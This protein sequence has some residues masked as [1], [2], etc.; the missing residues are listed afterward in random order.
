MAKLK[1]PTYDWEFKN[2]LDSILSGST[3]LAKNTTEKWTMFRDI[4]TKIAKT[5]LGPKEW[6]YQ[7][8]FDEN[9]DNIA[10][11]FRTKNKAFI[12]WQSH[13]TSASKR[14]KCK[15]SWEKC[16]TNGGKE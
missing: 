9:D 6:V 5:V 1:H 16:M 11:A 13:P 3:P 2:A 12:E 14:A 15:Q 8:W 10:K 7:D 4:V